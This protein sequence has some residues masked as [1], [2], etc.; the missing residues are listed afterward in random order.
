MHHLACRMGDIVPRNILSIIQRRDT[1]VLVDSKHKEIFLRL[2]NTADE[3]H[4]VLA[5]PRL[6][7]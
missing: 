2:D 6:L 1:F 4:S 7:V 5:M 3:S